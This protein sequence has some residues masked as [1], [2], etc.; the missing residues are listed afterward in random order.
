MT[1]DIPGEDG[2]ASSAG[3]GA[4]EA[5]YA[6]LEK[7]F[8][9]TREEIV[10]RQSAY[11]PVLEKAKIAN[12]GGPVLDIGCGRGEWL[13]LL[14]QHGYEVR[15]VDLNEGFV[16]DCRSRGLDVA[17]EE[18]VQFL[19]SQPAESYAAVT[20]FHLVEHLPFGRLI[21]LVAEVHRVLKPGGLVILETPNPENIV[22]GACSFHFDPTH[23]AP[24]PP[25]LLQ[26]VVERAGFPFA[27][28][29]RVNA[30]CLDTP[31][32]YLQQDIPGA[33]QVNASIYLLNKSIYIAPDY[34]IVGQKGE[35]G[36][37]N[38]I[39]SDEIN[40]LCQTKPANTTQYRLLAAEARLNALRMA[41]H[42]E[43]LRVQEA[44]VR[45]D[46]AR[47]R[48]GVAEAQAAAL[49]NSFSW[50]ATASIRAV[51]LALKA[52]SHPYVIPDFS[53]EILHGDGGDQQAPWVPVTSSLGE[54]LLATSTNI[55]LE[56]CLPTGPVQEMEIKVKEMES[57]AQ[58]TRIKAREMESKAEEMES[59]ALWAERQVVAIKE[60]FSWRVAR[61]I[62]ALGDI[63]AALQRK[64]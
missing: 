13:D 45:L 6:D 61:P 18:A 48:I 29:A 24:I 39:E 53:V 57:R 28:V 40:R 34:A 2:S 5:F 20:S 22:V 16:L 4:S 52:I 12:L 32:A 14:S 21:E 25:D 3:Q 59:R 51:G 1:Q 35:A 55:E 58:D 60:T 42:E 43:D 31:L 11:L 44:Q 33:L 56:K 10:K 17:C 50:R 15:G 63:L 49:E 41:A 23:V 26:F 37:D 8:R 7:R 62:R 54:S 19:R 46:E 30:D 9:G 38:V 36:D 27:C 64:R 47:A